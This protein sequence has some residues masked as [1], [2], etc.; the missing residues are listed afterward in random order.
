VFHNHINNVYFL[1][2]FTTKRMRL[3][4]KTIIPAQNTG[5]KLCLFLL[6]LLCTTKQGKS[7][8]VFLTQF[9]YSPILLNAANTGNYYGDWRAALNYRNQW[10]ATGDPY[11]TAILSGD[12]KISLFNQKIGVGGIFI[13]DQTA[14][15]NQNK[16]FASG[17]Y[18]YDYGENH[19]SAGLQ[20]GLVFNSAAN[21][22]WDIFNNNTGNFDLDNGEPKSAEGGMYTDINLGL[23][24][25]RS[26][27]IFEPEAGLSFAHLNSPN[28]SLLNG[29]DKVPLTSTLHA[30]M[31]TNI[32]DEIY[33]LPTLL[34]STSKNNTL[35]VLGVNG[36][37]RLLSNRSSVKE[38]FGGLYMRNGIA[39][40]V[41]D[42]SLLL[43]ATVGRLDI[44]LSYDLNL[45]NISQS[46]KVSS[47]EISLI[48]RSISTVLNSYSIPCERF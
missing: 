47:F 1:E 30:S 45:A 25:R 43:G 38:V 3:L 16:L 10:A 26:I 24:W 34:F 35:S 27:N 23:L 18:F 4:L 14:G 28:R 17:S 7:Q 48:Y 33:V 19:F 41:S 13:S 2:R 37:Y 42:F 6:L 40:D 32:N 5:I 46:K 29:T 8:D 9:N 22:S 12:K 21:S 15:I 39:E 20:A 31:K 11:S 36:G 44:A